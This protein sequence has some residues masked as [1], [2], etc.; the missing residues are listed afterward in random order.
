MAETGSALIAED[1]ALTFIGKE[2]VMRFFFVQAPITS[3][4]LHHLKV[5]YWIS[6]YL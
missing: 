1:I 5:C 4:T 6:S 3:W 2:Q